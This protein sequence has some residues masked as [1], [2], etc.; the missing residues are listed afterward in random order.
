MAYATVPHIVASKATLATLGLCAATSVSANT[1]PVAH[2]AIAWFVAPTRRL[3]FCA[4]Q[5]AAVYLVLVVVSEML[6]S[7][8]RTY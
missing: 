1:T 3:V 7:S 6:C 2:P 5:S 8:E 4:T